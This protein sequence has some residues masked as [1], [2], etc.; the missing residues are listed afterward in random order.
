MSAARRRTWFAG[1]GH[2]GGTRAQG[3]RQD[4]PP[5]GEGQLA[6]I[7]GGDPCKTHCSEEPP[8]S[9]RCSENRANVMPDCRKAIFGVSGGCQRRHD[10]CGLAAV[11]ASFAVDYPGRPA[12]CPLS[13]CCGRLRPRPFHAPPPPGAT[14]LPLG[15]SVLR[16]DNPV[17]APRVCP[18]T[19]GGEPSVRCFLQR[20]VVCGPD[21]RTASRGCARNV[22]YGH[23]D[24]DGGH[25]VQDHVPQLFR[26]SAPTVRGSA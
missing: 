6:R 24:A 9:A 20:L 14:P 1:I 7:A 11:S 12:K 17:A 25:E 23:L 18:I 4:S 13:P 16:Q 15:R 2:G 26:T 21:R 10:G 22:Q 19:S 3:P 5:S 8:S